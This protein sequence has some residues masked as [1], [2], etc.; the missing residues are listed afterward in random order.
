MQKSLLFL[1]SNTTVTHPQF[2]AIQPSFG[3]IS[4]LVN[5]LIIVCIAKAIKPRVTTAHIQAT[6][7]ITP[8]TKV[9]TAPE[10]FTTKKS[11]SYTHLTLP[12]NRCV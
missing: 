10:I 2:F 3:G 8:T 9:R 7:A 5:P 4:L 12:T 11:V 6:K 1:M